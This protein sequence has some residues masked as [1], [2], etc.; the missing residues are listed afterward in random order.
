MGSMQNLETQKEEKKESFSHNKWVLRNDITLQFQSF[1]FQNRLVKS[2]RKGILCHITSSSWTTWCAHSSIHRA[3]ALYRNDK[4]W[5]QSS[6]KIILVPMKYMAVS[7]A[8]N[9]Q[10]RNL[11]S[12]PNISIGTH[13][14]RLN[15][16]VMFTIFSPPYP[17]QHKEAI[18]SNAG[19]TSLSRM[20]P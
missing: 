12:A 8:Y 14:Y 13:A 1:Q 11:L 5:L 20:T 10:K 7:L 17:W 4:A 16:H 15:H 2:H 18:D 9:M 3:R 19:K 6:I